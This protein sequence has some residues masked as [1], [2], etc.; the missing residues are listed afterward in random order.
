M[1]THQL[2]FGTI[3][4]LRKDLAEVIID[5]GIEVCLEQVN[6]ADEF[7]A[8]YLQA[9]FSLLFNKK[10]KYSFEFNAQLKLGTVTGLNAVAV[11]CYNKTT[12]TLTKAL[13]SGIPRSVEWNMK[14]F[15]NRIDAL[16]WLEGEQ[17]SIV[18]E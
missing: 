9:P 11:I 6:E 1:D 13:S 3:N 10:N 8:H 4:I 16:V 12:N 2:S 18:R 15:S 7:L 17:Q 5:D 14:T